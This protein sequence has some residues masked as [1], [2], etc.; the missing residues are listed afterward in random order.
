MGYD[1][2]SELSTRRGCSSRSRQKRRDLVRLC[3][4]TLTSP[5]RH[6]SPQKVDDWMIGGV[7][8]TALAYDSAEK[9]F[10]HVSMWASPIF[11]LGFLRLSGVR[12]ASGCR[13]RPPGLH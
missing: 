7:S 12:P 5:H 9:L 11:I 2:Y 1:E 10:A 8:C 13:M 4:Q 6:N 3:N